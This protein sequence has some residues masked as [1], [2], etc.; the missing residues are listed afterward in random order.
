MSQEILNHA[1]IGAALQEMRSESAPQRVRMDTAEACTIR[2]P[3][4]DVP[5]RPGGV[6]AHGNRLEAGN[7]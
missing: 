7:L 5:Y 2:E 6:L 4:Q 1:Q 3:F